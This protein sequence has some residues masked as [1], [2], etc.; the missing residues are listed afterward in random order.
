[1]GSV[2]KRFQQYKQKARGR[3]T[4]TF[5]FDIIPYSVGKLLQTTPMQLVQTV[6]VLFCLELQCCSCM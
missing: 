1:M 4:L 3:Q 6:N 2:G 5:A